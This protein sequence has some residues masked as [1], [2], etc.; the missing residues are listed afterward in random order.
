MIKVVVVMMS[1]FNLKKKINK[2][3]GEDHGQEALVFS[4]MITPIVLKIFSLID[5]MKIL[6]NKGSSEQFLEIT[7]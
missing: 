3:N 4:K 2:I 7:R 5:I 1:L 6:N